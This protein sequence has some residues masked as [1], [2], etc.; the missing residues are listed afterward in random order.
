LEEVLSEIAFF[1]GESYHTVHE[2][3]G[4][5]VT[6]S[7][8]YSNF[9]YYAELVRSS[10]VDSIS[11]CEWN[12]KPFECCKYFHRME[13][14]LGICYAINSMQA[15]FVWNKCV[16]CITA[17]MDRF[18]LLGNPKCLIPADSTSR[19]SSSAAS[20]AA[21]TNGVTVNGNGV[22]HQDSDGEHEDEELGEEARNTLDTRKTLLEQNEKLVD[23]P[24]EGETDLQGLDN[25]LRTITALRTKLR[26]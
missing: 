23:L 22:G 21:L 10:C 2:C 7:C 20:D 18:T 11:N 8:F 5:E 4:E 19:H 17:L 15:G 24:L 6:A 1:R 16:E 25:R 12:N 26:I 13:T 3:S 14:E 9:S